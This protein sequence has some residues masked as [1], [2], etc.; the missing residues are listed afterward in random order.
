MSKIITVYIDDKPYQAEEGQNLLQIALANQIDIPHLC[1]HPDLPADHNCRLCLVKHEGEVTTSCEIQAI[2][3]L[4]IQTND[5]ELQE[6]RAE[7]LKLILASHREN[8]L[9][10]QKQLP[11]PVV[12]LMNKYG[13][14]SEEYRRKMLDLAIHKMAN[15][16]E[17]D[18]NLCVRCGLCV[19]AC[20]N[21]GINFLKLEGKSSDVH[22]SYNQNPKADCVYCGQCTVSCPV[23]AIR[24][25][26]HLEVVEAVLADPEKIVIV[27]MAPSVRASIGEE[28]GLEPGLNLEKRM[29]T[30]LRQLGFNKIF[31]VNM[32]ADITT[33]VEAEELSERLRQKFAGE[34]TTLPMFTSCCPGWVKFLEFYYPE[35]IPHL[36]TARSPHIHAGGAYK[37]WWA[38]KAGVD[39]SRIVVVSLMPCTSKKYEA[40]MDKLS[41]E[42]NGHLLK[43]VDL[44]LTTRET[45]ALLK[46]HQIDLPNLP[47]SEADLEGEYSGAAAIYGASGGVMESA[48]RTTAHLLTGQELPK[49]D[50]QEV[51]GMKGIKKAIVKIG[52]REIKVAV[53]VTPRN[54]RNI[55]EKIKR[56]VEEYDYIEFMACPGGCIGGG[57]QPL[58]GTIETI[59]KRITGLY[60]IDANKKVRRAH[61]NQVVRDFLNFTKAEPSL[62]QKIL[63]TNY[64][65][66][67]KFE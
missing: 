39:P 25:Q 57:G 46:K 20:A 54:A 61:E 58:Q 33:M 13:V 42:Y 10:C 5:S 52:G 66:K 43:P 21:I 64:S 65:V 15:A 3:G 14:T 23:G 29:F 37:T 28:F 19:S 63:Y 60:A 8:C 56:G 22:L 53:V 6:L 36:T 48:L 34:K 4:R 59:K 51:R 47:E 55:L 45:A 38:K 30:A 32:G 62:A 31:D 2:D 7:N 16:A 17:F 12:G 50:L 27:Q 18:P 9:K 35:M 67:N 26:S 41:F 11:C 44:V 24:E 40:A 49:I 1:Y